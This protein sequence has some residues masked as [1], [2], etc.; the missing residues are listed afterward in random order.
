MVNNKCVHNMYCWLLRVPHTQVFKTLCAQLVSQ[1]NHAQRQ[2]KQANG[3]GRQH[4]L[5]IQNRQM[6]WE[7]TAVV[8]QKNGLRFCPATYSLSGGETVFRLTFIF[9]AI[10]LFIILD[11]KKKKLAL[12]TCKFEQVE[13]LNLFFFFYQST[14]IYTALNHIRT[15]LK[16]LCTIPIFVLFSAPPLKTLQ[17]CSFSRSVFM[18][19]FAES[20][21][22]PCACLQNICPLALGWDAIVLQHG[23]GFLWHRINRGT[24][25]QT[26]GSVAGCS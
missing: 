3:T 8:M 6:F 14:L 11:K 19:G 22:L 23:L 2:W 16:A 9:K 21:L 17:C 20:F 5:L 15:R 18:T 7:R 4:A 24:R 26:E 13:K 25:N 10:L 1:R 12:H